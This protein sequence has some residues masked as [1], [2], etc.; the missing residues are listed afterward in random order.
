MYNIY[1]LLKENN[2]RWGFYENVWLLLYDEWK[3]RGW[4]IFISIL[5]LCYFFFCLL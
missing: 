5:F 2:K 1:V 4:Y 3:F